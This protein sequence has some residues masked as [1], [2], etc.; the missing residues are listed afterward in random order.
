MAS[1][2]TGSKRLLRDLNQSIVF[3]LI[4][5]RQ[6][7]SR[8][9]LARRS[10]LPAAT[11]TRIVGDFLNA[12][13]I[14]EVVSEVSSGGRRPI[15]LSI[16]PAAGYAI[17]VKLRKESMTI[18]ICD[19]S[20]AVIRTSEQVLPEGA[21]V[22]QTIEVI[23]GS[24]QA[25]IAKSGLTERQILGLGIGLA[26]LVDSTAG[27]C[28]YSAILG[29]Q[30]VELRSL[31][32]CQLGV[33][34]RVD[35]DV[36]TLAIAEHFFGEGRGV[37]S[38]LLI[39][40]GRG[41]GMGII[42]GGE[43]YRGAYGGAGEFG[44]MTVDTSEHAPFCTCGKRGCLEAIASDHS[45]LQEAGGSSDISALIS[46]ARRGDR[47]VCDIFT[48]AGRALG[49]ATANLINIFDP[50][51]VLISGEG[52]QAGD[53]L[54]ESLRVTIP[55][56][57]FGPQ[58]NREIIIAELDEANWAR[59]AACLILREVFQPPIYEDDV[60]LAIDDLL[61]QATLNRLRS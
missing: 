27:R 30:D 56:H 59:G 19:L 33:P 37:E 17:G 26:G 8:T 45:M 18:A 61:S 31:L 1:T 58:K 46:R 20:C 48:C 3:N 2:R 6:S 21:T 28:R 16:N 40:T 44:H 10:R 38:F 32:E 7:I 41:V 47:A 23:V 25:L 50:A 54:M 43:I 60:A 57:I 42:I 52:L 35:N 9:E 34:V 13:L 55:Q 49:I 5:E 14:S 29:W 11:I 15:L 36:N 24:V 53:L 51:R 22:Q 12:G 39:T 4:A